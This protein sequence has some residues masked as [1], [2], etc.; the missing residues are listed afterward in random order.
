MCAVSDRCAESAEGVVVDG[1]NGACGP[2]P[3]PGVGA[4]AAFLA[5]LAVAAAIVALR[6]RRG[7]AALVL[8]LA[9]GGAAAPGMRA[10]LETRGDA[11][12]RAG[13]TAATIARLAGALDGFA[14]R[15]GRCVEVVREA[16][17]A[18]T[19]IARLALAPR[20]SCAQPAPIVLEAGALGGVCV[21]EGGGGLRCGPRR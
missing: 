5:V 12:E 7:V 9:I 10:L 17:D 13:S 11:P 19:P 8:A 4:V 2:P 3:R 1:A 21:E 20:R 18:A 6:P 14:A 16:G 15:H